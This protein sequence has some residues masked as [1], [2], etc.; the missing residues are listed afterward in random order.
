MALTCG[1]YMAEGH[2]LGALAVQFW[3]SKKQSDLNSHQANGH[4]DPKEAGNKAYVFT[5]TAA[6]TGGQV[7]C[8]ELKS[9]G[10]DSNGRDMYELHGCPEHHVFIHDGEKLLEC[11]ENSLEEKRVWTYTHCA[12]PAGLPSKK[13]PSQNFRQAILRKDMDSCDESSPDTQTIIAKYAEYTHSLPKNV[14]ARQKEL[15]RI[16]T[17]P[18]PL[19]HEMNKALCDDDLEGMRYFAS[20]IRELRDVF[21]TDHVD[22]IITPFSGTVWRGVE[23]ENPSE[24]LKE[25][26]PG[27]DFVWSGFTSTYT[28]K[29][30]AMTV[31]N[32]IF[33]MRCQPPEGT[34]DDEDWEYAP[35]SIK[36]F[37]NFVEDD[38]ILFPPNTKFRVIEIKSFETPIVV[39]DCTAF[40]TDSG[41]VQFVVQS[42][43][44]A[45]TDNKLHAPEL[46]TYVTDDHALGS[47]SVQFGK[48]GIEEK[49]GKPSK[50]GK[51]SA[52][53]MVTATSGQ[54]DELWSSHLTYD[55]K[56]A[57]GRHTYKLAGHPWGGYMVHNEHQLI[58]YE[59]DDSGGLGKQRRIWS[60]NKE[61]GGHMFSE[62]VGIPTGADASENFRVAVSWRDLHKADTNAPETQTVVQEYAYWSDNL[63]AD[64][65]QRQKELVRLY[66]METPLYHEMNAALR[67]DD[68]EKMKYFGAYIKELR[69]VFLTDHVD[70]II[71]PYTGTLWRGVSIPNVEEILR[72]YQP[73]KIFVWPAFTST[74]TNK[75]V[76]MG[77]GNIVFEMRCFPPEGTYDDEEWEYAPASVQEYSAFPSEGE[78]L[79]PPNCKFKVLEVQMPSETNGLN[80]P[81]VICDVTAF[82]THS[83][84]LV[85]FGT[86][87]E[88]VDDDDGFC[89]CLDR[90]S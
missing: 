35:A 1:T 68:L 40:D 33:E 66:T 22:Q 69:D 4:F 36:E 20:F 52:V 63:A 13:F 60:Y 43:E 77:F 47:L 48:K 67:N 10:Q 46:G 11:D 45:K 51:K 85:D 80:K 24:M 87:G 17:T 53:F 50:K 41:I 88:P 56:D 3:Q 39:C 72:H 16:Y 37:S 44:G 82:D 21:L 71:S 32:I 18:T 15:V 25:Y 5:V 61:L 29:E 23:V 26:K 65:I 79:F 70:Q 49:K 58:E 28:G 64:P 73:G 75:N 90:I 74:T 7:W 34:Y 59:E 83:G 42:K 78:I 38:E 84:G 54:V 27:M 81:L 86:S 9:K 2:A 6:A 57:S 8:S 55:G 14:M 89:C 62:P 30:K 31:G 19:A 12:E 76:A